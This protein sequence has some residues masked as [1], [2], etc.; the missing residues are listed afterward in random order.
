MVFTNSGK[1]RVRDL[2]DADFSYGMLGTSSTAPSVTDATLGSAATDTSQS[3]TTTTADKQVIVDFNLPSTAA[4][5]STL[6]ELGVFNASN[7]MFSRHTYASLL[8]Q[9]TEQWQFSVR[10]NIV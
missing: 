6:Y 8:K 5:G 7:S 10:Y 2:L 3:V 1:N 4:N 9:S